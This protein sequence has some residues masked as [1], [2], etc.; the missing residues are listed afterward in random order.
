MVLHWEGDCTGCHW[1]DNLVALSS[2]PGGTGSGWLVLAPRL[3][4]PEEFATPK[5]LW[6]RNN[7]TENDFWL[8][9]QME[10]EIGNGSTPKGR[11]YYTWSTAFLLWHFWPRPCF[12]SCFWT[13]FRR[14]RVSAFPFQG[15]ASSR[16]AFLPGVAPTGCLYPQGLRCLGKM[17]IA[18]H[19]LCSLH[20][21][22]S[23]CKGRAKGLDEDVGCTAHSISSGEVEVGIGI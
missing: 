1:K 16:N 22:Y 4:P 19:A 18:T 11:K 20:L 12:S 14:V 3:K 2:Q 15:G 5:E 21:P 9:W 17:N 13:H 10:R 8:S 6:W 23:A 7:H